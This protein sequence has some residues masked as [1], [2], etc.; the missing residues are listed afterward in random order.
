MPSLM[1]RVPRVPEPRLRGNEAGYPLAKVRMTQAY[2]VGGDPALSYF[3]PYAPVQIG[4]D[5]IG[6]TYEEIDR[7]GNYALVNQKAP[8]LLRVAFDFR[9]AHRPTNGLRDVSKDLQLLRK[10]ARDNAPV[11]FTGLGGL[12]A[13][14]SNGSVVKFR[15]SSLNAEIVTVGPQQ[16][17]W[18]VNC[19]IELIEDRNPNFTIVAFS[20]IVYPPPPPVVNKKSTSKKSTGNKPKSPPDPAPLGTPYSGLKDDP[21]LIYVARPGVVLIR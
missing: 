21:N 4:F 20:S 11:V 10:I 19:A 3:F 9:I 1:I 5:S 6:S 7:P 16:E 17:P 12:I 8:N 18:Q 2:G 15:I 14:W 13:G